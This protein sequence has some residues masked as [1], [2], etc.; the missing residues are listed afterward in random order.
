MADDEWGQRVCAAVVG[1][2]TAEELA[3]YVRERLSPAKRPRS[4]RFVEALPH[5]ATGK[6]RRS[7][8]AAD[9][10]GRGPE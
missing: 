5:T 4:W 10:A 7:E 6:V 2:A 1:E 8:L 3:A 9:H